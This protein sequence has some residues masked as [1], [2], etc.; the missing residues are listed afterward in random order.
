MMKAE[1]L[2][3][4]GGDDNI[5]PIANGKILKSLIPGAELE[6]IADGGHLFL[7]SHAEETLM[8]INRF[9]DRAEEGKRAA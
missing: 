7:V 8:M 3:M 6:V 1:T 4:M 2:I 5:V 9:L